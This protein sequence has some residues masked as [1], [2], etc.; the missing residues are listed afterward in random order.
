MSPMSPTT[1]TRLDPRYPLLWRDADTVQFGLEGV[2]RIAIG[3]PWTEPLLNRLRAGIRMSSFD[4]IAHGVGAPRQEARQ[5]LDQ[6]RPLLIDDALPA[7][8]FWVD[9]INLADGRG[10]ERLRQSLIDEGLDEADPRAAG[11]VG[12]VMIGGA[13][14]ALQLAGYLRDDLPHL[15]IAFEQDAA[16]IGPLVVPGRTP[17]LSCRDAHERERDEAWPRLHAQLVGAAVQVTSARIAQAASLAARIL[18][19]P[20]P[21][22]GLLVRVSPGGR[23]AW[24]SVRHHAECPCLELSFRSPRETETA[25]ARPAPPSGT[26]TRPAFA[27]PA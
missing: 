7:P 16:V 20:T 14:A 8:P 3:G 6:L 11:A 10:Q 1:L 18:R 15:P 24:R 5:L 19:T 12:V 13:A 27:R 25:T 9:A 21:S 23:R 4:V 2:V 26:T 17:C 22:A